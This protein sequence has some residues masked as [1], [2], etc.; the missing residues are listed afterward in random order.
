VG[1]VAFPKH[2]AGQIRLVL[3]DVDG[4]LSD[5]GLYLW[6]GPDG[7]RVEG[8]RFDAQ[9]GLGIK[10]LMWAGL[11]VIL[12]SGRYSEATEMRARELGVTECHQDPEARKLSLVEDVLDRR[13]VGWSEVAMVADDL[14][15]IPVLRKVGLPVA[16]ANAVP[17]V[18]EL[19]PFSTTREG[20]RGAVREFA[21]ALLVA[22]GVWDHVL[23]EYY[24]ART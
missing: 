19:A 20:G 16:V 3:L 15:D 7:E 6:P 18:A 24:R 22:Q 12:I 9:D 23:E 10:L 17:E 4:V 13:G 11:E 2:L 14:A 8:K 5:G 21:R 1:D